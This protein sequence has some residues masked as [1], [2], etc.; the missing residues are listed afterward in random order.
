[1]YRVW[2]LVLWFDLCALPYLLRLFPGPYRAGVPGRLV[3]VGSDCASW[4]RAVSRA[5]HIPGRT[6]GVRVGSSAL[7]R[8]SGSRGCPEAG[9]RPK[10]ALRSE[11]W[12]GVGSGH[13]SSSARPFDWKFD[14]P[15][16]LLFRYLGRPKSCALVRNVVRWA[17]PL[18]RSRSMRGPRIY[19]PDNSK[20]FCTKI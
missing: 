19:E 7:A 18:L 12:A 14:H 6:C 2:S 9:W 15:C 13:R 3:L 10:R 4:R 17:E 8:P 5:W 16:G 20:T 1:M 11:R